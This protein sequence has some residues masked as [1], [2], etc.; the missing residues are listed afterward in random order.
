MFTGEEIVKQYIEARVLV[1]QVLSSDTDSIS[2]LRWPLGS[3]VFKTCG[4]LSLWLQL[5]SVLMSLLQS[6]KNSSSLK[7]FLL[8]QFGDMLGPF[9]KT[10][11]ENIGSSSIKTIP[12]LANKDQK[13][14]YVVPVDSLEKI[15]KDVFERVLQ[16]DSEKACGLTKINK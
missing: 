12:Q 4:S 16:I 5:V 13:V 3:N 8:S 11:A 10:Q 7:Q 1:E 6:R 2:K 14:L 15:L 9:P